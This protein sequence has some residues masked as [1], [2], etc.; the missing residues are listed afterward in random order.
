MSPRFGPESPPRIRRRLLAL[1]VELE[2]HRVSVESYLPFRTIKRGK[3]LTIE[4]TYKWEH[5][6]TPLIRHEAAVHF[7]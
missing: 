6:E 2:L 5:V 1:H 3:I 7:F 4:R